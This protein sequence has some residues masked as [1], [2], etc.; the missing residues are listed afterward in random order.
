LFRDTGKEDWRL[1]VER[2]QTRRGGFIVPQPRQ[3]K[4]VPEKQKE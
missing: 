1:R 3:W 4:L 2:E